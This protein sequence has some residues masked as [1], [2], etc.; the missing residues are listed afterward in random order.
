MK[1]LLIFRNGW[2]RDEDDTFL[3]TV[4]KLL[5]FIVSLTFCCRCKRL[6]GLS[7]LLFVA[8]DLCDLLMVS[9]CSD[10]ALHTRRSVDGEY[11]EA[12]SL[13]ARVDSLVEDESPQ[14]VVLLLVLLLLK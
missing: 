7:V 1:L 11:V 13:L 12:R 6:L 4:S 3:L 8:E 5:L 2:G 14:H 10:K 9:L